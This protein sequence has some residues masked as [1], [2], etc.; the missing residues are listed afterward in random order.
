MKKI[1]KKILDKQDAAEVSSIKRY[2]DNVILEINR[3][4]SDSEKINISRMDILHNSAIIE[5]LMGNYR[6]AEDLLKPLTIMS[7]IFGPRA[8]RIERTTNSMNELGRVYL[9]D[10]IVRWHC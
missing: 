2:L 6:K 8:R 4:E 7:N 10:G 3:I 5:R 1:F 9:S